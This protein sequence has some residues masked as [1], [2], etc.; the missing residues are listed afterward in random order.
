MCF[1]NHIDAFTGTTLFLHKTFTHHFR[2]KRHFSQKLSRDNNQNLYLFPE[3]PKLITFDA[4]DTLLELRTGVGVFYREAWV[5]ANRDIGHKSIPSSFP[6]KEEFSLAFRTS[7][8]EMDKKYP[9]YGSKDGLASQEWWRNVVD[10]AFFYA[11]TDIMNDIEI[12]TNTDTDT[13]ENDKMAWKQK[14]APILDEIF[15]SLYMDIFTTVKAWKVRPGVIEFLESMAKLRDSH[16]PQNNKYTPVLA[17][18]SNNDNRL[19]IILQNLGLLEYFDHVF[20]S[21]ELGVSKPDSTI[22]ERVMSHCQVTEDPALCM[23]VGDHF[24]KDVMGASNAGW[25]AVHV[26]KS[27]SKPSEFMKEEGNLSHFTSVEH[28]SEVLDIYKNYFN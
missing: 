24:E 21:S 19:P 28:I 15:E 25:H 27:N 9:C 2:D 1:V 6:S 5:K 13:I 7:F 20:V 14:N 18:L 12:N 11:N 16:P 23:H 4:T 17:V 8:K 10:N 3:P 22:F 26:P